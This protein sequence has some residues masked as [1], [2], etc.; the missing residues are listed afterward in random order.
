M[1]NWLLFPPTTGCY[2]ESDQVQ[3][4]PHH[5]QSLQ[6]AQRRIQMRRVQCTWEDDYILPGQRSSSL[7]RL[8]HWSNVFIIIEFLTDQK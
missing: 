8:V 6:R 2:A 3:L 4:S 7:R 5:S 1:C